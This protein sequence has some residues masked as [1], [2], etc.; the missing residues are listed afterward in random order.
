MA[1]F[2]EYLPVIIAGTF[3]FAASIIVLFLGRHMNLFDRTKQASTVA[4]FNIGNVQENMKELK[5]MHKELKD[6]LNQKIEDIEKGNH[7]ENRRIWQRIEKIS[8]EAYNVDW[9]LR[10]LE[11]RGHP[12]TG[13]DSN[14]ALM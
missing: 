8:T 3:G 12:H 9:R 13:T 6:F 10:A 11:G 2:D 4:T 1:T 5:E 14:G 7:E